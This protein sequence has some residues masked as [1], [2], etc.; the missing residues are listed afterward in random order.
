MKF[1]GLTFLVILVVGI[2]N[3]FFP[4]WVVMIFIAIVSAF[5]GLPAFVSFLAGALGMGLV[6]VGQSFYLS[7]YSGSDLPQK[8]AELIGVGSGMTLV[9]ITGVLGFIIG[10]LSAWTGSAFR[11]VFT[12]APDNIYRG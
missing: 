4:F 12:P 1:I 9:A 3:P 5:I 8:M 6:W 10:G 11:K 7:I 2:I